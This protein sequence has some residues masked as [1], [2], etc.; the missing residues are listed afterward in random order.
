MD[1][2]G[3]DAVGRDKTTTTTTTYYSPTEIHNAWQPVADAI[4]T[5]SPEK[6]AEATAKLDDLKKEVAKGKAEDT[7]I[8]KLVKGLVGLVPSPCKARAS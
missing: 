8:A 6:Q 4:R 3:G 7:T 1:T 2:G 5:A